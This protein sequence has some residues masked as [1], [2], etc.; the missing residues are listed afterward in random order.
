[1]VTVTSLGREMK[2]AGDQLG[3]WCSDLGKRWWEFRPKNVSGDGEKCMD[4]IPVSR[5]WSLRDEL[6]DVCEV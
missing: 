3:G 5:R 6:T 1:M 4:S 2:K